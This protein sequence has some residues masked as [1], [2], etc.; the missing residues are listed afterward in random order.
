MTGASRDLHSTSSRGPLLQ[1]GFPNT[2]SFQ[3]AKMP[4]LTHSALSLLLYFLHLYFYPHFA[5]PTIP[6]P[7][8]HL[9]EKVQVKNHLLTTSIFWKDTPDFY[10]SGSLYI[11]SLCSEYPSLFS[12]GKLLL[13]VQYPLLPI[14]E[15]RLNQKPPSGPHSS[16]AFFCLST[17]S[18][19]SLACYC[20]GLGQNSPPWIPQGS[21]LCLQHPT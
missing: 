20:L 7:S 6:Y 8:S 10:S 4:Q 11:Y 16:R 2:L 18:P 14:P 13:V 3:L 21:S 5:L 9:K 15:S 12:P 17:D 1:Q 19:G